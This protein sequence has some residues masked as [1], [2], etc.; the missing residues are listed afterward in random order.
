MAETTVTVFFYECGCC[1]FHLSDVEYEQ[2]NFTDCP[3]CRNPLSNY[4]LRS[5]HLKINP[6]FER[7]PLTDDERRIRM[8]GKC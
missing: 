4:Y 1:S 7:G 3:R 6:V 2:A 8:D 5:K